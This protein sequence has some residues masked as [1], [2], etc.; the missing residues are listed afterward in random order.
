MLDQAQ[1]RKLHQ[2]YSIA[3][4]LLRK[5]CPIKRVNAVSPNRASLDLNSAQISLF[6]AIGIIGVVR[7]PSTRHAREEASM[8]QEV[9]NV[10]E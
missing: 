4:N 2:A 8:V 3:C 10:S 1:P 9:F 5:V 6:V 7:Q